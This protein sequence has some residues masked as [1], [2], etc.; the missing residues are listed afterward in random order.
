MT[1]IA[2]YGS[3]DKFLTHQCRISHHH[4]VWIPHYMHTCMY[5]VH[6]YRRV[7][8]LRYSYCIHLYLQN[9]NGVSVTRWNYYITPRASGQSNVAK[10]PERAVNELNSL[11]KV[12]HQQRYHD[13]KLFSSPAQSLSSE[14]S[15]Y[16]VLQPQE[17]LPWWL[18]QVCWHPPF[19]TEHSFTSKIQLCWS[20]SI[21]YSSLVM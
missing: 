2:L 12:S 19:P 10:I 14:D 3:W 11:Q 7:C 4:L 1:R 16:P 8:I 20:W 21:N 6:S 13:H 5:Q 15:L 18:E 17:K 9:A